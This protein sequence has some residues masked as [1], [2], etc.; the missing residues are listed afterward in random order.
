[1][2]KNRKAMETLGA[3]LTFALDNHWELVHYH[4]HTGEALFRRDEEQIKV[5]CTTLAIQTVVPH[6]KRN[7]Q[8]NRKG[9]SI[10]DIENLFDNPRQHT[11]KGYYK[12]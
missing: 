8:L 5:Y 2:K 1:M 3:L 6:P 10:E 12:R 4:G 7:E 9:V 11:G